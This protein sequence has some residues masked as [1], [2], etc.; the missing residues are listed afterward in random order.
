MSIPAS[1]KEQVGV[2][3]LGGGPRS[4]AQALGPLPRA[5]SRLAS[6]ELPQASSGKEM[7]LHVK[8]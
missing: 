2:S 6:G 4:W 3:D 5:A 7:L 8:G 1:L